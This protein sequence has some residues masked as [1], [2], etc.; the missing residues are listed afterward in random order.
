MSTTRGRTE[1]TS[2]ATVI[3]VRPTVLMSIMIHF[4]AVE[5]WA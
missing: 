3:K 4:P 1:A 2:M 5:P